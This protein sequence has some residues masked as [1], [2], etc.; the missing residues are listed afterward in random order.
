MFVLGTLFL[1]TCYA[2]TVRF[3]PISSVYPRDLHV[4][5]VAYRKKTTGEPTMFQLKPGESKGETEWA[6]TN[7]IGMHEKYPLCIKK[8]REGNIVQERV[9]VAGCCECVVIR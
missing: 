3:D 4:C 8:L 6:H 7:T 1:G 5:H 9:T 2:F